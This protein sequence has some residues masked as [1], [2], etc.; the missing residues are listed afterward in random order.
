MRGCVLAGVWGAGKTSIYERVAARLIDS[1]CQSLIAMPQAATMTTHTYAPGDGA[2]HAA[3]ILSWLGNL[4][5]FLEDLDRRFQDSGLTDH[6][7]AHAWT[8]TCVMEGLGFDIPI[9]QLPV[10]RQAALEIEHRLAIAGLWLVV[11]HVPTDRIRARCVEST[12]MT[13]GPRWTKYVNDFDS[14][15]DAR[16]AHIEC[17]QDRLMSWARTSP[18]RLHVIS[19]D[20]DGWDDYADEVMGLITSSPRTRHA[21]H[22][23][24]EPTPADAAGSPLASPRP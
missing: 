8:P 15:D 5:A 21:A 14:D 12:R 1:G 16:A 4:T 6:R 18:M 19:V 9:Y 22:H 23:P 2:D 20:R 17:A 3:G 10:S 24:I 13:R 7:F 11:L